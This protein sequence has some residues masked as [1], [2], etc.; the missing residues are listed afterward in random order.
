MKFKTSL[1]L[2]IFF[3]ISA[4]KSEIM[5]DW[6]TASEDASVKREQQDKALKIMVISDLNDSYGSVTYSKEVASVIRRIAQ[7]KP[8]IILCG[9]DMVAGQKASL[10]EE[11]LVE[12]WQAF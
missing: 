8:D 1:L 12:M 10:T 9:G 3:I 2:F 4:F 7:I 5:I 11:R 6:Q